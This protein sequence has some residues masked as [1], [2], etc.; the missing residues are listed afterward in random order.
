MN[1]AERR[2]VLDANLFVRGFREPPANALPRT[3]SSN[4]AGPLHPLPPIAPLP[5][6]TA[7]YQSP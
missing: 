5:K 6:P 1:A 2:Y 7:R 4:R 3:R